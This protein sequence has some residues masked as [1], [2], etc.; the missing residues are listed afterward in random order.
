MFEPQR[1]AVYVGQMYLAFNT[2]EHVRV[3]THHFDQ[4]VRAAVVPPHEAADFL[5]GVR[6]S[7]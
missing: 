3:L 2:I 6:G 5:R 1:A 4:L 7:G